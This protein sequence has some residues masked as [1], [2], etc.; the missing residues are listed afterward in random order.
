M[1]KEILGSTERENADLIAMCGQGSMASR[2][3]F[4]A[5]LPPMF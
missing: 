1:V 4:T 2:G 3:C 5:V